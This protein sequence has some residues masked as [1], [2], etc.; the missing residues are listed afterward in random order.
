[1]PNEIIEVPGFS[2]PFSSISH[3]IAAFVAL[4]GI[5]FLWH[6]GKGNPARITALIIYTFA[7]VFLFSMSG[8]YHLLDPASFSRQV[9]KRLDHAG[10]WVLIAGSF[11]PIHMILFRSYLRWSV[12][13]FVWAIAITG[14][15]LEIVFFDTFPEWLS[16]TLYL[17]LGWVGAISGVSF[18]NR[19]KDVSLKWLIL[20]GV[21]YSVGAVFDFIKWPNIISGVIGPHEIFHVGVIL[22]GF[23][24][25]RFIDLWAHH[26]LRDTI[27]FN[28]GIFPNNRFVAKAVRE[29]IEVESNSLENIK[30]LIKA[31]V[32]AKYH[33]SVDPIIHLK[34]SQEELL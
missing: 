4:Y 23:F 18:H 12:L 22:G 27:V 25:W 10:I 19:Y 31:A 34:Y 2:E 24:H 6:K 15:V 14:L 17:S 11:T 5:G 9:F 8:I 20:G 1:M 30:V 7:L 13:L 33:R 28:V 3:L 32:V 29:P 21:A 26:P 16:L